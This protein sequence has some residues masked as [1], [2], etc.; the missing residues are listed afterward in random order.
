MTKRRQSIVCPYCKSIVTILKRQHSYCSDTCRFWDKVEIL[1][2]DDCWNWTAVKG[3]EGYGHF[4][5][6]GRQTQA[7]RMAWILTNGPIP[8]NFHVLHHCDNPP[9]CN[10][11]HLF[12]GTQTDN[13]RDM[14]EKNRQ[15]R[16]YGEYNPRA[17]LT[18]QQVKTIKLKLDRGIFH[19]ILAKRYKVA[20]ETIGDINTGKRWSHI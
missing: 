10:P 1:G 11:A 5:Y 6:K 18:T 3:K 17:K 7:H 2:P 13:M 16:Q 14:F 15:P 8:D 9:C 4:K 19:H 12:L 20:R